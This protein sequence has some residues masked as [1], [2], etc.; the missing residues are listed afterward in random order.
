MQ[1]GC[2]SHGAKPAE[3]DPKCLKFDG[4]WCLDTCV[5]EISSMIGNELADRLSDPVFL[6]SEDLFT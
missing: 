3:G 4:L 5:A 1:A 2:A 6:V